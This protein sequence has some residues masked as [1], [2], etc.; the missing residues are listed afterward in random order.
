[1]KTRW[2]VTAAA[3][4]FVTVSLFSVPGHAV[5]GPRA[6]DRAGPQLGGH[7]RHGHFARHLVGM[8]ERLDL[9][10]EQRDQVQSIMARAKPELRALHEARRD[11]RDRLR[12]VTPD[13]ADYSTIVA[14]VSQSNGSLAE[15]GTL[16]KSQLRSDVWAVLTDTQKAHAKELREER[17]EKMRRRVERMQ[18]RL[19]NAQ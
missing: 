5:D 6:Q 17:I 19:D 13:D 9:S 4:A 15:R 12:S 3:A 11:N 8:L 18:E 14:E 16:L 7:H 2:I 1:M 10:T